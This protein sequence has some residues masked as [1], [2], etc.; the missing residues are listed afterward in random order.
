MTLTLLGDSPW[1]PRSP[2]SGR[3]RA[4]HAG[5]SRRFPR[6]SRSSCRS[7]PARAASSASST[8]LS[9]S[10]FIWM[11]ASSMSSWMSAS[12]LSTASKTSFCLP[13]HALGPDVAHLVLDLCPQ[14]RPAL[15]KHLFEL[16]IA[17]PSHLGSVGLL[18]S[19]VT[20]ITAPCLPL[21]GAPS[22]RNRY[23][24]VLP[25][26][27]VDPIFKLPIIES[28]FTASAT[29]NQGPWRHRNLRPESVCLHKHS[30]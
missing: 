26:M 16:G 6:R 22:S 17:R 27:A 25:D 10:D 20:A 5:A 7:R 30:I 12:E 21:V 23:A 14:F 2:C 1:P 19:F 28:N 8:L 4:A 15:Y 24:T 9:V 11:S 18:V 13:P 29:G 3:R